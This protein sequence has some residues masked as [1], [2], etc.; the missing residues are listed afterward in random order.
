MLKDFLWWRIRCFELFHAPSKLIE[1]LFQ[2]L[3][4]TEAKKPW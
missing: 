2:V 4:D 3:A 1:A